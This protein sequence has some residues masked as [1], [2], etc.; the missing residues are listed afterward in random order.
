MKLEVAILKLNFCRRI[1]TT[2]NKQ[3]DA[4]TTMAESSSTQA[5]ISNPLHQIN[6]AS[7]VTAWKEMEKTKGQ[8]L[9]ARRSANIGEI[10]IKNVTK[11][12]L[13][14]VNTLI[15]S[16]MGNS[17]SDKEAVKEVMATLRGH[18]IQEQVL[19]ANVTQTLSGTNVL[20]T[21]MNWKT[22][23]TGI[24]DIHI[25][26]SNWRQIEWQ[27]VRKNTA[28]C[29][30]VQVEIDTNVLRDFMYGHRYTLSVYMSKRSS[31][32]EHVWFRGAIGQVIGFES[33]GQVALSNNVLAKM[34]RGSSTVGSNNVYVS[35]YRTSSD[36]VQTT[37]LDKLTKDANVVWTD[38]WVTLKQTAGFLRGVLDSC[39]TDMQGMAQK[40][41]KWS[42]QH[43]LKHSS[44]A[45]NDQAVD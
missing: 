5:L 35:N 43:L 22:E 24:Y 45:D 31:T 16:A 41:A 39:E 28:H 10:G 15:N 29:N 27:Y 4:Q 42:A 37:F 17:V 21:N 32:T 36:K 33:N 1:Y 14:E 9:D 13:S 11:L 23:I 25:H 6:L 38:N 18:E 7:S 8:M 34:S 44:S 20:F 40:Y 12:P 19:E 3:A 26:H 2:K 30:G